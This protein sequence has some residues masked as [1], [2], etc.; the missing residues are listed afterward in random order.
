MPLAVS[1]MSHDVEYTG[2]QLRLKIKKTSIGVEALLVACHKT[3]VEYE[4]HYSA[5]GRLCKYTTV[6]FLTNSRTFRSH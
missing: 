6:N 4:N 2:G 1:L 5:V 3:H